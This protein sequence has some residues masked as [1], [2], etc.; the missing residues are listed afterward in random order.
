[1]KKI[2]T[3]FEREYVD[4]KVVGIKP[5]LTSPDLQWVL[6]G[7]GTVDT[8]NLIEKTAELI[9]M[10]A[11]CAIGIEAARIVLTGVRG[12]RDEYL[13]HVRDKKCPAGSCPR[14]Y[15]IKITDDCIGCTKC[16]RNCPVG[17]IGG[18]LKQKHFIDPEKCIKCGLCIDNCPKKAIV[19]G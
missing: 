13:A 3:L 18:E 12:F 10:S 16:K 14:L 8:V 15:T 4:H 19:K 11:D 2:P 7:E 17:A 9:T 5:V 1:M 6:D